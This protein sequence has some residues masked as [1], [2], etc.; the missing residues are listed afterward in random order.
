MYDLYIRPIFKVSKFSC[1][2]IHPPLSD[3]RIICIWMAN[4]QPMWNTERVFFLISPTHPPP[5]TVP[6]VKKAM[7]VGEE[8]VMR[9]ER[10]LQS[11]YL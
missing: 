8:D 5:L 3:L 9:K 10:A 11:Y 1:I 2:S 7:L 4:W 6:L